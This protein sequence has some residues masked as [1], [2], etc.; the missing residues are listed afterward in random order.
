MSLLLHRLFSD[1]WFDGLPSESWRCPS[2]RMTLFSLAEY[3]SAFL[4]SDLTFEFD[5]DGPFGRGALIGLAS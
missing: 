5:Q 1:Y 2:H 3:E 4:A